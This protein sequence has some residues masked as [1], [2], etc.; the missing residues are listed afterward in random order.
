MTPMLLYDPLRSNPITYQQ[1]D[2]LSINWLRARKDP[3]LTS[4][5]GI[6]L[7]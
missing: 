2:D 6:L 7:E 5:P 1:P 4:R 3:D